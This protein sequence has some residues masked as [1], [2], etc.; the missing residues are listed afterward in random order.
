MD[1]ADFKEF[2]QERIL[3]LDPTADITD[4]GPIDIEVIQPILDYVGPSPFDSKAY[5]FILDRLAQ[6]NPDD[7]VDEGDALT[8]L[9]VKPYS[10]I[11]DPIVQEITRIKN[12]LTFRF[13]SRMSRESAQNLGANFFVEMEDGSYTTG[14][15]RVYFSTPLSLTVDSTIIFRTAA[16]DAFIPSYPQS[17]SQNDMILNRQGSFFYWDVV[18]RSVNPGAIAVGPGELIVVEGLTPAIRVSNIRSFATGNARESV[19]DFTSRARDALTERSLVTA[20]GISARI[21]ELFADARAVEVAGYNDIEMNRDIIDHRASG[22][23]AR[24]I[25]S[26][27]IAFPVT[28]T[29]GVDDFIIVE[30]DNGAGG[31][32]APVTLSLIGFFPNIASLVIY[33]NQ[34]WLT[35]GGIG[36]IASSWGASRIVF[37]SGTDVPNTVTDLSYLNSKI[38]LHQPSTRSAWAKLGYAASQLD[39][40]VVGTSGI[41]YGSMPGGILRPNTSSGSFSPYDQRFHVGGATDV[42]IRPTQSDQEEVSHG[43]V[44]DNKFVWAGIRLQLNPTQSNSDRIRDRSTSTRPG[45]PDWTSSMVVNALDLQYNYESIYDSD[46][47]NNVK[48]EPGDI[49][50]IHGGNHDGAYVIAATQKQDPMVGF[51]TSE[52]RINELLDGGSTGADQK[53]EVSATVRIDLTEPKRK[54]KISSIHG[55]GLQCYGSSAL[56]N[57]I[58]PAFTGIDSNDFSEY[59]VISQDILKVYHQVNGQ[60]S[61]NADEYTILEV[62]GS[63]LTLNRPMVATERVTFAIYTQGGDAL[64]LPLIRVRSVELLDA[65]GASLGVEIPYALPVLVQSRG[66]SGARVKYEGSNGQLSNASTSLY[67][68]N[69]PTFYRSFKSVGIEKG[70]VLSLYHSSFFGTGEPAKYFVVGA[71]GDYQLTLV[72]P[73][74]VQASPPAVPI[75]VT[76]VQFKIGTPARGSVRLYF[77]DPVSFEVEHERLETRMWADP[78][79]GYSQYTYHSPFQL[80]M[81]D[82]TGIVR[83]FYQARSKG[84]LGSKRIYP[85]LN[86]NEDPEMANMDIE[87][88]PSFGQDMTTVAAVGTTEFAILNFD[89]FICRK[90]GL[91]PTATL[92]VAGGTGPIDDAVL[93]FPERLLGQGGINT[94]SPYSTD[95]DLDTML[96][97]AKGVALIPKTSTATLQVPLDFFNGSLMPGGFRAPG[98]LTTDSVELRWGLLRDSICTILAPPDMDP[99]TA[100]DLVQD[101]L[102]TAYERLGSCRSPERFGIWVGRILRNRCLDHLKSAARRGLPLHPFLPDSG[103]GPDGDAEGNAL[104]RQLNEALAT[105]PA[106]QREAFLMKHGEGRS[107]D[108][109]ADLAEA[110]VSAM[111]MRVHRAREALQ[112]HLEARGVSGGL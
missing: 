61:E 37:H 54:I 91:L 92:P 79:S 7:L 85:A 68:F 86:A 96:R 40:M 10:Y 11:L 101:S 46:F 26:Q 67:Y 15:G 59:G 42:Y 24:I 78:I 33:I 106:E 70:D 102:V 28:F 56:V 34:Q 4:G 65:L 99:D 50:N 18:L 23:R 29:L 93:I 105:L 84:L 83:R 47:L 107:Y 73:L 12:S 104:R 58:S 66:L 44:E 55:T 16:G 20:R 62:A 31:T 49:I 32:V 13:P 72:S 41:I 100:A 57:W 82:D 45:L 97:K 35:A 88:I 48:I 27:P 87:G 63:Q 90:Y 43:D 75:S 14:T 51:E 94:L 6:F 38:K 52:L 110:S 95:S 1:L 64:D 108:E 2:I 5:E 81:R 80:A 30:T 22:D 3:E 36:T 77:Q 76:D 111:K 112:A 53:Y 103:R 21:K 39:N 69:I 9:A 74:P 89:Q 60:V 25:S 8:D 109:M 19:E 71:V 98:L 17:I